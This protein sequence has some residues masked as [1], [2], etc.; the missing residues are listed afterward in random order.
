VS[1]ADEVAEYLAHFTPTAEQRREYASKGW[2]MPDGSFFIRPLDQGGRQDLINAKNAVGRATPN[3]S[4]SDTARRNTVR[5]HVMKRAREL[6]LTALI[7]PT[8]KADGSLAQSDLLDEILAHYGVR[9]MRWGVRKGASDAVRANQ[10][11]NSVWRTGRQMR[12]A[13][14]GGKKAEPPSEESA[15]ALELQRRV[16]KSGTSALTN[17]DLQALVTRMNLEKQY[18]N[19]NQRQ[20]STGR[21]MVNQ[22][23]QNQAQQLAAQYGPKGAAWVLKKIGKKAAVAGAGV[24]ARAAI[25][26]LL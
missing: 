12:K 5:R 17:K 1:I 26:A 24:A 10:T 15:R 20:V 16:Q 4:E 25:T 6:G 18:S 13:T 7:P 14:R 2:A 3:A 11:A 9:G 19:L 23:A 21:K 8:W 22:F